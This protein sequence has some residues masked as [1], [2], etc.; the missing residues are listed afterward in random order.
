M[1]ELCYLTNRREAALLRDPSFQN[2]LA[3]A[4]ANGINDYFR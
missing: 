3:Q 1:V 2:R 4:V